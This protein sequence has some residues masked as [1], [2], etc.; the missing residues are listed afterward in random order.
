VERIHPQRLLMLVVAFAA[1]LL[2]C[3]SGAQ[4]RE[5][6]TF[7]VTP[8]HILAHLE[9]LA[10]LRRGGYVIH[11]RHAATDPERADPQI[12]EAADCSTQRRLSELGVNQS[13]RIGAAIRELEIP[14]GAVLSSPYCRCLDTARL[15]FGRA[16]VVPDLLSSLPASE[17]EAKRLAQALYAMLA[18]PPAAGT[19]TVLVGHM[20]NLKEATGIWPEPEGVAHVFEPLAGGTI[21]L[22][23]EI[24]PDGWPALAKEQ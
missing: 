12:E 2:P 9:L 23:A 15:A 10:A 22:I 14:V 4:A 18:T 11:I 8:R 6:S 19:N 5:P 20:A 3:S 21:R 1:S 17:P 16:D 24:P 7:P 13:R